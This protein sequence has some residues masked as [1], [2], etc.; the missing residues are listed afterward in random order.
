MFDFALIL[1]SVPFLARGAVYTVEVS[2][3]A[4][5]F[6]LVLGWLLGLAAVSGVGW[7]RAITWAYVQ[8][9]RGTVGTRESAPPPAA[10]PYCP[11]PSA[12]TPNHPTRRP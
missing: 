12:P 10:Q 5:A 2:V 6:G 4:I 1:E 3:L 9:I 8:F 7:L 11:P